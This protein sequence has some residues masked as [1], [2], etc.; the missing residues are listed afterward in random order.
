MNGK[1]LQ[2][3]LKAL[4]ASLVLVMLAGMTSMADE[5]VNMTKGE[6]NVYTSYGEYET[7]SD[8]YNKLVIKKPSVIAVTGYCI[9]TSSNTH[10]SLRVTLMNSKLKALEESSNFVNADTEKYVTYA[11]KKGTYYIKVTSEKKFVLAAAVQAVSEK[12]GTSKKKA[13]TIKSGKAVKGLMCAGEKASKADWYKFKVTKSKV[14]KLTIEVNSNGYFEYYIYGPSYPK[15][16]RLGSLKDQKGTYYSIN[17]RTNKKAKIKTGTYYIKAV[18]TSS[19][20]KS[21]GLYSVKWKLS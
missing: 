16:A 6:D 9:Y 12:S 10:S 8:I 17:L 1:I 2:K 18:R 20:P 13:V 7:Y 4:L 3:G 21:S 14:L 5:Y 15:G 19:S 11:L